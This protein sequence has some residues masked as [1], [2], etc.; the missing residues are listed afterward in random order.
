[1]LQEGG[2]L[3]REAGVIEKAAQYLANWQADH[4]PSIAE[5]NSANCVSY[6]TET[7][8]AATLATAREREGAQAQQQRQAQAQLQRQAQAEQ[9]ARERQLTEAEVQR[10]E[11]QRV[12]L[13]ER[14][15]IDLSINQSQL[16]VQTHSARKYASLR[17]DFRLFG[18]RQSHALQRLPSNR[19]THRDPHRRGC[20]G[21]YTVRYSGIIQSHRRP[22]ANV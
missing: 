4:L 6:F 5:A 14:A 17:R 10:D 19:W 11:Q 8:L 20:T 13:F 1:L 22:D 7:Y 15:S 21:L 9:E 3:P 2:V 16:T 18:Q 12:A